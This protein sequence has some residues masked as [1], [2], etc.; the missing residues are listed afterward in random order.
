MD[1][2]KNRMKDREKT[3][4]D[5]RKIDPKDNKDLGIIDTK[6]TGTHKADH[7]K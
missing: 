6:K 7:E 3:S 5:L 1:N 4:A 2:N